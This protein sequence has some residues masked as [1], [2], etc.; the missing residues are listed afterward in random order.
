ALWMAY[1]DVV[2][3]AQIKTRPDRLDRIREEVSAQAGEPVRLTEVLKPGVEEAASLLPLGLGR[4]LVALTK[5]LGVHDR[6]NL[7]LAVPSTSVWGF[8]LLRLLAGLRPLR[9][10]G[11]RFREE[12]SAI[13]H[14]L[15]YIAGAAA[16]DLSLAREIAACQSLVKG[17]G[18]THQHGL[19]SF[20]GIMDTLVVP[21]LNGHI[22]PGAAAEAVARARRAALADPAGDALRETL[23]EPEAPSLAAE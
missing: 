23:R 21:A 7:P 14:W 3:V 20:R 1:E 22:S 16:L 9:R 5:R 8:F 4:G 12:Q 15:D 2:R 18:D 11:H 13:D 10:F 19:G 6:L 17:Y